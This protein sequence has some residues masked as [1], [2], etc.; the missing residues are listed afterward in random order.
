MSLPPLHA[1][2]LYGF[3]NYY[4]FP[5]GAPATDLDSPV[6][7]VPSLGEPVERGGCG[8]SIGTHGHPDESFIDMHLGEVVNPRNDFVEPV[9]GRTKNGRVARLLAAL[10]DSECLGPDG[11]VVVQNAVE[12]TIESVVEIVPNVVLAHRTLGV[13]LCQQCRT[14]CAHEPARLSHDL[15]VREEL[16]N[17]RID[18]AGHLFEMDAITRL[19][20]AIQT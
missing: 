7:E 4:G 1:W 13:D 5:H 11:L 3:R 6:V 14:A 8:G 20:R 10:D 9:A 16:A 17:E 15:V 19:A 12:A 2:R 18:D